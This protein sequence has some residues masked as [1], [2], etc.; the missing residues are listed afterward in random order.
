MQFNKSRIYPVGN[1][2][3]SIS[4]KVVAQMYSFFMPAVKNFDF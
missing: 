1:G 2:N 3:P 4:K